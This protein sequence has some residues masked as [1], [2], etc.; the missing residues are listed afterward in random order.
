MIARWLRI[1][2]IF[3]TRKKEKK[4]KERG[5]KGKE[6]KEKKKKRFLAVWAA[7]GAGYKEQNSGGQCSKLGDAV[8]HTPTKTHLHNHPNLRLFVVEI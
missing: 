7:I 2:L 1:L 8:Q 6:R 4:R 3:V 5:R